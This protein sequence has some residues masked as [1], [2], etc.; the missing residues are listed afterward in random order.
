MHGACAL[1]TVHFVCTSHLVHCTT[2]VCTS[3]LS[4]VLSARC[5]ARAWMCFTSRTDHSGHLCPWSCRT[6]SCV[7]LGVLHTPT[8]PRAGWGLRVVG[9]AA[10]PSRTIRT[11][12][13]MGLSLVL[14]QGV[15]TLCTAL[16]HAACS[17]CTVLAPSALYT[18]CVPRS[19]HRM[20]Y[21]WAFWALCAGIGV[22]RAPV[23]A[24][25][26]PF[27]APCWR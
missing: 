21:T 7:V 12:V 16:L 11:L 17:M 15:H 5:L 14:L 25:V 2:V 4:S 19:A 1:C 22:P 8:A 9:C 18:L 26:V 23:P 10:H 13:S 20:R 24:N 3:T 27:S 6:C